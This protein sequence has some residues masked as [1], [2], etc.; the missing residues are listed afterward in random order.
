[1]A[2]KQLTIRLPRGREHWRFAKA[3]TVLIFCKV[4]V[5]FAA[6]IRKKKTF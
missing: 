2:T 5:N 1:M 6:K 3:V 4:F